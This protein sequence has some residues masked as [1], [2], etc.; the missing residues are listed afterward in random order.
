LNY[1]GSDLINKLMHGFILE[2]TIER[3]WK[4][5]EALYKEITLWGCGLLVPDLVIYLVPGP[6]LSVSLCFLPAIR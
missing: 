6:F 4:M 2:W 1:E 5:W 3:Q